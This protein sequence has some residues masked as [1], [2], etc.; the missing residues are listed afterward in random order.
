[1]SDAAQFKK[2]VTALGEILDSLSK[3]DEQQRGVVLNMA[4]QRLNVATS[5]LKP[6]D[7]LASAAASSGGTTGSGGDPTPKQFIAQKQPQ[8]DVERVVCLAFYLTHH[9]GTSHFK[10]KNISELNT[11]A[12]EPKFSNAAVAVTNASNNYKYL[13]AAG[14]GNKQITGL[15]EQVVNAL[16]D[17]QAVKAV[18]DAQK[19]RRRKKRT[20]RSAGK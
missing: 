5:P 17:R 11:K 12:G 2:E 1:M 13:S 10:T 4:A 3:L 16:P 18:L 20:K 8:T 6:N 14:S 15:G 19:K 7:T 9:A